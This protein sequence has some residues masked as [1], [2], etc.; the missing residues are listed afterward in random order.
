MFYSFKIW[1]SLGG[2]NLSDSYFFFGKFDN[3]NSY[4]FWLGD[5]GGYIIVYISLFYV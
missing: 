3:E 4:L 2:G 1:W 5:C